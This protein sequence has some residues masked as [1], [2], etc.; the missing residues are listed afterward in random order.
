MWPS[1]VG[2][3]NRPLGIQIVCLGFHW[4]HRNVEKKKKKKL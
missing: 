1:R 3:S 4:I 2:T